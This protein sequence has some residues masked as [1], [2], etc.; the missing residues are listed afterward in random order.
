[1]RYT[2]AVDDHFSQRHCLQ[3]VFPI[4]GQGT[5]IEVVD[6]VNAM[7]KALGGATAIAAV[8][9]VASAIAPAVT[10]VEPQTIRVTDQVVVAN[11]DG[12]ATA[13]RLGFART[14]AEGVPQAVVSG[15]CGSDGDV[16]ETAEGRPI[17]RIMVSEGSTVDGRQDVGASHTALVSFHPDAVT[18][19]DSIPGVGIPE[20]MLTR[21]E[22]QRVDPVACSLDQVSRP[23][24]GQLTR[25][26]ETPSSKLVFHFA[27]GRG[28]SGS[29]V[30]VYEADGTVLAIGVVAPALDG[31]GHSDAS[32]TVVEPLEDHVADWWR[33]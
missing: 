28:S 30:W 23:T 22:V 7:M 14:T 21:A 33:H 31:S 13:C 25:A 11:G 15:P 3:A 32:A 17:G 20:G 10:G 12:T 2:I 24:C 19:D 9:I 18:V 4:G 5:G 16:V 27:S 6:S 8:A 29:P 26:V 1:M